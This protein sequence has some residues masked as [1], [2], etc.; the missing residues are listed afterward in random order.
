MVASVRLG[1]AKVKACHSR[2]ASVLTGLAKVASFRPRTRMS[3]VARTAW[4]SYREQVNETV[5]EE[6]T[7]ETA[8]EFLFGKANLA[9]PQAADGLRVEE[10]ELHPGY[11]AEFSVQAF[12]AQGTRNAE[13]VS[14]ATKGISKLQGRGCARGQL[15]QGTG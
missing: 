8:E 2:P 5:P 13:A 9:S 10:L 6:G 7:L 1:L 11:P 3:Q 14:M 12:V 15:R 4:R